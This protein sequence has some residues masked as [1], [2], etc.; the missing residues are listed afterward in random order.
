[1]L[2]SDEIPDKGSFSVSVSACTLVFKPQALALPSAPPEGE[3]EEAPT[4]DPAYEPPECYCILSLANC[5]KVFPVPTTSPS[6]EGGGE[7]WVSAVG[8]S[9]H[10]FMRPN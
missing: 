8:L 5:A 2:L 3:Q 9:C 4:D 6:E 1:M 10:L 7:R